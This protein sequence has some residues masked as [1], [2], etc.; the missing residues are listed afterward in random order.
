MDEV[1]RLFHIAKKTCCAIAK[2]HT[3]TA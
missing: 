1:N 2:L 3:A